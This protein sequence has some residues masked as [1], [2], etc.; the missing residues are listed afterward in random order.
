MLLFDY[1]II[2]GTV[3]VSLN[4]QFMSHGFLGIPRVTMGMAPFTEVSRCAEAL[5]RWAVRASGGSGD[6]SAGD[7]RGS[8]WLRRGA[9]ITCCL[10][11]WYGDVGHVSKCWWLRTNWLSH[12][13][14]VMMCRWSPTVYAQLCFVWWTSNASRWLATGGEI[15][16]TLL[17]DSLSKF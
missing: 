7:R 16:L 8:P 13:F 11:W 9:G 10:G 15:W 4:S 2:H 1:H 3:H 6:V 5:P 17:H 14:L 12:S